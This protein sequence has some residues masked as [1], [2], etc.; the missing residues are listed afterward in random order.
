MDTFN[1]P[2]LFAGDTF[3]TLRLTESNGELF[4]FAFVCFVSSATRVEAN[5][6]AMDGSILNSVNSLQK[7]NI[8]KES[9]S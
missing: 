2:V 1:S 4:A 7:L 9:V 3:T 8:S 6:L 5:L